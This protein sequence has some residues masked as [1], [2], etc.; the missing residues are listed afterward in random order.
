[1]IV[2]ITPI[3][4]FLVCTF[5]IKKLIPFLKR[6]SLLDYP[7]HRSN[8][9]ILIPKGAGII[10]IPLLIISVFGIFFF[11]G[12]LDNQW[13]IF[14]ISIIILYVIS[15]IDDIK[16]LSAL[17]R[18]LTHF[19]CVSISIF[20][21]KEDIAL[22]IQNNI[23]TWLHFNPLFLFYFL[24]V[25]LI[26]LWIWIINLFNFMDGMDG[27]TC[28]Q[29]LTLFLTTNILCLF[30][31]INE[32]FQLISLILISLFLA[33]Y[34]FNK[35][36]ASVFLGD[37]GSIPIGYI[38]GLLLITNFLKSGPIIPLLIVFLYYLFDSTLTLILR[39]TKGKNIFEAHSDHFYQKILRAGQTHRQVLNKIIILLLFL[40]ILSMISI[41]YP[42]ISLVLGMILTLGFLILLQK[43][44][45]NE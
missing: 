40:F 39:L 9:N 21:L 4:L 19:F 6:M 32:N 8:H 1:M 35:P 27:L 26:V 28:M 38:S 25:L 17:I 30:G 10:L 11:R 29:V 7:S 5:L 44:S 18:L 14:L 12:L 43:Q 16:N 33:F 2:F 31:F 37:V 45:K 24:S 42:I 34:K 20:I 22:F 41:K 36:N 23:S 15:L 13:F 3:I